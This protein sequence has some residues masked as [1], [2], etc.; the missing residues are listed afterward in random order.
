MTH[1]SGT[2]LVLRITQ[3]ITQGIIATVVLLI[4]SQAGSDMCLLLETVSEPVSDLKN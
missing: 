4:S 3:V 1:V 2:G